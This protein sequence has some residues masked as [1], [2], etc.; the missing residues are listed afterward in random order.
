[1]R[2]SFYS[3]PVNSPRVSN[4]GWDLWW[5]YTGVCLWGCQE[6][7]ICSSGNEFLMRTK[8]KQG[9][10]DWIPTCTGFSKCSPLYKH[11]VP[12]KLSGISDLR[13]YH[14]LLNHKLG[15]ISCPGC[16][17]CCIVTVSPGISSQQAAHHH[18]PYTLCRTHLHS[19][20]GS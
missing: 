7:S 10:S 1:M 15:E 2:T 19:V 16:Q 18:P 17:S 5:K 4:P 11:R 3:W 9:F 13:I 20:W 14:H 8:L 12:G 6:A